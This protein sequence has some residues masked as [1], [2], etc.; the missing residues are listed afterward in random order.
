MGNFWNKNYIKY[1]STGDRNKNLSVKEYLNKIKPYLRD[2]K[3]N[4]D[5]IS[6]KDFEEECLMESKSNNIEFMYHD[7]ANEVADDI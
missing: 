4:I 3:I 2:I 6:L 5:F 1:K 7:N